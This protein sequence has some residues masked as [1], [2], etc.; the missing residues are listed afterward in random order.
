MPYFEEVAVGVN[1]VFF[2]PAE[3]CVVL[4]QLAAPGLVEL[5]DRIACDSPSKFLYGVY[6]P[7]ISLTYN[8]GPRGAWE[9]RVRGGGLPPLPVVHLR[10]VRHEPYDED[11]TA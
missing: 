6:H 7:H 8:G 2:G 11:W 9:A 5:H 1:I 3:N 10:G 4:L